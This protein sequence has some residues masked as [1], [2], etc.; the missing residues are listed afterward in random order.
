[1][2]GSRCAGTGYDIRIVREGDYSHS[3]VGIAGGACKQLFHERLCRSLC[4]RNLLVRCY[5]R[6]I[7][8]YVKFHTARNVDYENDVN[9]LGVHRNAA[10][11]Q[12][13]GTDAGVVIVGAFSGVGIFLNT[14]RTLVGILGVVF[15]VARVNDDVAACNPDGYVVRCILRRAVGGPGERYLYER[16]AAGRVGYGDKTV[17]VNGGDFAVNYL[18]C[19]GFVRYGGEKV[20]LLRKL[21][22]RA[23]YVH[24][25]TRYAGRTVV[26][27]DADFVGGGVSDLYFF[28]EV[29]GIGAARART[30]TEAIMVVVYI[31]RCT[32]Y[33]SIQLIISVYELALIVS[34]D[35]Q[36]PIRR[37]NILRPCHVIA[38][39]D[40]RKGA[41]FAS[42]PPH[43]ICIVRYDVGFI[44]QTVGRIYC[45]RITCAKCIIRVGD[46]AGCCS[47]VGSRAACR[48]ANGNRLSVGCCS[49][50]IRNDYVLSA[51][52]KIADEL[53]YFR[54]GCTGVFCTLGLGGFDDELGVVGHGV[55]RVVI[56]IFIGDL[57]NGI[58]CLAGEGDN[59]G[60]GNFRYYI[61]RALAVNRPGDDGSA[62]CRSRH[63]EGGGLKRLQGLVAR[64]YL[65][66][67]LGDP[68]TVAVDVNAGLDSGR[69]VNC[70]LFVEVEGLCTVAI[71]GKFISAAAVIEISARAHPNPHIRSFGGTGNI[72]NIYS[73]TATLIKYC[74][75]AGRVGKIVTAVVYEQRATVGSRC[76]IPNICIGGRSYIL[77]VFALNS[78]RT[79][80]D[81]YGLVAKVVAVDRVIDSVGI[82]RIALQYHVFFTLDYISIVHK[83]EDLNV[84]ILFALA[85]FGR[86]DLTCG[87]YDDVAGVSDR[88]GL[89]VLIYRHAGYRGAACGD[90]GYRGLVRTVNRG[91][92]CEVGRGG[93]PDKVIVRADNAVCRIRGHG[94]GD[95]GGNVGIIHA[96]YYGLRIERY[97][98][99]RHIRNI[100]RCIG[101]KDGIAKGDGAGQESAA[102]LECGDI[103]NAAVSVHGS[104]GRVLDCP[105]IG[106][107]C[108]LG[109]VL[110]GCGNVGGGI[111][112][113]R[114]S[115]R[116]LIEHERRLGRRYGTLCVKL[117]RAVCGCGLR[118]A[119]QVKIVACR[120][121]ERY[122]VA[123]G[124]GKLAVV[125][126]P[127]GHSGR[128]GSGVT[129]DIPCR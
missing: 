43:H 120:G 110:D 24:G 103:R 21:Y 84:V 79:G 48:A 29:E 107:G 14:Y 129:V 13:H 23:A 68:C 45:K 47:A 35:S 51:V 54:C 123:G 108:A 91:D 97:G 104:N 1:M 119:E 88:L 78:G 6:F 25:S 18:P 11:K 59:T 101:G 28:I 34:T 105:C 41:V 63:V 57:Y 58:A 9:G 102:V 98:N 77:S 118:C 73:I 126:F 87:L 2:R 46:A 39:A 52:L 96:E 5:G 69:A 55:G 80:L 27:V 20:V 89:V 60:R 75:V 10:G 82:P 4:K 22:A 99:E 42:I 90:G 33:V 111:A 76:Q 109:E 66:L 122:V 70:G 49:I 92:G 15:G 3:V 85:G 83:S 67:L 124:R 61:R 117:D 30:K 106:G 44:T 7:A 12:L 127:L 93:R 38:F 125:P 71:G 81:S 114:K 56:G 16:F 113:H 72:Y 128:S 64:L 8:V 121:H 74:F 116:R 32:A 62:R 115:Y 50:I 40:T 36:I 95:F 53:E 100:Y 94:C 86:R 65:I 19:N 17:V 31:V 37:V 112:L 26:D